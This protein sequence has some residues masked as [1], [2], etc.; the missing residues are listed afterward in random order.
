MM[1]PEFLTFLL[2]SLDLFTDIF[3]R[4]VLSVPNFEHEVLTCAV[5]YRLPK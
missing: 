4:V 2:K 3:V 5:G 1:L